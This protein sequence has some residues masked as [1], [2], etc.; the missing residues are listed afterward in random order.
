MLFSTNTYCF[1]GIMKDYRDSVVR[2][3]RRTL[4]ECY[5]NDWETRIRAP[6]ERE[7]D[8][9]KANYEL[10]RQTGEISSPSVDDA[11]LLSVNHFFNLFDTYFNDLFPNSG[12][13]ADD[14]RK[15][16]KQAVLEWAKS[17]KRLRDPALGHPSEIELPKPDALDMLNKAKKILEWFDSSAADR[18][19]DLWFHL[20]GQNLDEQGFD[21][22][23]VLEGSVLPP[24]ESI[25]PKFVGRQ[26]ELNE[27]D[28]WLKDPDSKVWL[29]AGDG[30]KGKSA[31]A[32]EFAVAT[33]NAPPPESKLVRVIWLSAKARQFVSGQLVDIEAPDFYDLNSALD[34][35]LRAYGAPSWLFEESTSI[36]EKKKECQD[37]LHELPSLIVLDDV[38]SLEGRNIEAMNFFI[39]NVGSTRSKLLLTSRRMPFFG[40]EPFHTAVNGF[41]QASEEGTAFVNS[42]IRMFGL[43]E[44][45]FSSQ[46]KNRIIE[47]CDG[48][49][50]FIQDLLRLC[51][52]GETTV[53]AINRWKN[54]S[55]EEARRYALGRELDM[56]TEQAQEVLLTCALFQGAASLADV[57]AA[58]G[59]SDKDCSV[60]IEELQK[61]FL[62]PL[63]EFLEGIPRFRL[64]LNTR[65]LVREVRGESDMARRIRNKIDEIT[66]AVQ[67]SP[68]QIQ[69]Y[70]LQAFSLVDLDKHE[71][72]E[73]TLRNAL[74]RHRDNA[75]L[76]SRLGWVYKN[77]KPQP[78]YT[79]AREQF[80]LAHQLQS[81][82]ED[83][84]WHWAD[85]EYRRREWTS[86]ALAAERGLAIENLRSS[87]KL[88]YMAGRARFELVKDLWR[89][90]QYSR[91]EQEA[92]TAEAHLKNA[93]MDL[94]DVERG[95]YRF[96]SNIH[97]TTVLNYEYFIRIVR[98]QD[99][100][101]RGRGESGKAKRFLQLL[102]KS[103]DRWRNEHPHDDVAETE[104]ERLV[105]SFSALS[106]YLQRPIYS[107]P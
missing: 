68:S 48:S 23:R 25:A 84:Y 49:P 59:I 66:N 62:V 35:V 21:D 94:E 88:A 36:N 15:Q 95:Q 52:T 38:D 42:R 103:L 30:G 58:S 65:Q 102:A 22:H 31:I 47:A 100:F 79:D 11:D 54:S 69:A 39:Q 60:A 96:H 92:R 10:A 43:D 57:Q 9:I 45:Q 37:Y 89:Q 83:T 4:R 20:D 87:V 107:R 98:E 5:P 61:L 101:S 63:P 82:R 33:K 75:E 6:F 12:N 73:E 24:R 18:L 28:V 67:S 17:I 55:G 34:C 26:A 14:V 56:L 64:N 70:V 106:E 29:L 2:H 27:L 16:E 32:Y 19:G 74:E 44:R 99:R 76:Y 77:W 53:A 50:L 3:L 1:Q 97:R 72:A 46:D 93:L 80:D 90:A 85:L 40:M 51:A 8:G 41:A 104:T 7:W 13:V 78:R 81:S 86:S 91:A 105:R 71:E